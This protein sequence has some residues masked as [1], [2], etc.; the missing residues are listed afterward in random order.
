[1]FGLQTIDI[2]VIAVYSL[3]IVAIGV[4]AMLRIKN[5]EDYFLGGRRFGKLLHIFSTFG[6]ATSSDTAVGTVTTT[7]RNGAGGVW[8]ALLLLWATPFYWFTAP[9]YRRMRLLT[10]GDFFRER[11]NS[12][13]MAMLYSVMASFLLVATIGLGFKAMSVTVIGITLKQESALTAAELAERRQA[14]RLDELSAQSARATL[15]PAEQAELDRLRDLK[16]RHEFSAIN[17]TW[18]VWFLVA[19]IFLYGCLGGLEAAVWVDMLQGTLILVLSVLLLPFAIAR[20]NTLSGGAGLHD[21]FTALHHRLPGHFFE[22]FGSAANS[23]FTWYFV[24]AAS[25]MATLNVAVQANQFTSN[26]AA[27]NEF[28]ARVGSTAGNYLKRVCTVLWGVTGLFAFALYHEHISNPDL[29]WGHATRD[30]LGGLGFGLVGL[31]IACLFSALQSTASTHM[32]SAAGLFTRNVYEPL[33]PGRGERHYLM[34]G[35]V[36]GAAVIVGA[37]LLCTAFATILDMLKFLWEFNAVIAAAFWCGIKWRGA[38]RAAAWASVSVSLVLFL[39]LP[40]ALPTLFPSMRTDPAF[41]RKTE[42][43]VVTTSYKASEQDAAVRASEIAA[44]TGAGAPPAPIRAGD[45]L[46]RVASLAPRAICWSQ[47]ISLRDGRPAGAGLFYPEMYLLDRAF[48]LSANP[49]ALNETIRYACKILLPFLILIAVSLA[50]RGRRHSDETDRFFVRMRVPVRTDRA[51][52]ERAVA[53][54][55]ADPAGTA[56]ALLFPRTRLE[57]QKWDRADALGFAA[58]ILFTFAVI[59]LLMLVAGYGG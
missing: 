24:I 21:A 7:H 52:D 39:I 31:M 47:D 58:N 46:A 1:M 22:V 20:L 41:L 30:L 28:T 59:G 10:F 5:Q 15:A 42:A 55:C 43:R 2:V 8:S 27:R 16:P 56:R 35:R 14:V 23:D 18:L 44:W 45:M 26:A 53:A 50:G 9:W 40:A 57:F 36:M 13:S 6:Q 12:R 33:F 25:V 34:V 17:E 38:T 51:E 49:Y 37:A 11:Y 54:A 3:A 48:D 4:V 32:I 19:V 29:V